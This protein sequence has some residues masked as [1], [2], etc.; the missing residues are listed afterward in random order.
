MTN[1]ISN[2]KPLGNNQAILEN[3]A[4]DTA[5]K[6]SAL[7]D[8]R[9]YSELETQETSTP[10]SNQNKSQNENKRQ[11]AQQTPTNLTSDVFRIL[12]SADEFKVFSTGVTAYLVHKSGRIISLSP[13]ADREHIQ[14]NDGRGGTNSVLKNPLG[15]FFDQRRQLALQESSAQ[16]PQ[17][18]NNKEKQVE[19]EEDIEPTTETLVRYTRQGQKESSDEEATS[20]TKHYKSEPTNDQDNSPQQ[21]QANGQMSKDSSDNTNIDSSDIKQQEHTAISAKA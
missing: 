8:N 14:F 16:E 13:G 15:E 18:K 17:A 7:R 21:Y 20:P 11:E 9:L 10:N 3:S 12:G 1:P 5:N 4:I 19:L 6:D 2:I